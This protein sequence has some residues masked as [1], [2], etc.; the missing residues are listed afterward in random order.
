MNSCSHHCPHW[1]QKGRNYKVLRHLITSSLYPQM[2]RMGT[3]QPYNSISASWAAL[4]L[5]PSSQRTLTHLRCL[6]GDLILPFLSLPHPGETHQIY[7][8]LSSSQLQVRIA[9]K[10]V[11]PLERQPGFSH[12][13]PADQDCS[14]Y[15]PGAERVGHCPSQHPQA[16][17]A[18]LLWCF[19][20][21]YAHCLIIL[22][23]ASKSFYYKKE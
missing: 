14:P 22:A 3:R 17:N 18:T 7:S 5:F 19:L 13:A 16:M 12:R 21:L 11:I 23:G 15:S 4:Y 6:P 10:Q 20:Q 1:G 9:P 8:T 2:V